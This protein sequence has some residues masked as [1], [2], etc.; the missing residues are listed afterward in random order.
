MKDKEEFEKQF[1]ETEV[2]ITREGNILVAYYPPSR[3]QNSIILD[4]VRTEERAKKELIT[5]LRVY[6]EL[7]ND[8][9]EC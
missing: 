3:L 1:D 2:E 4:E 6:V 8:D 7:Q 9:A 5:S